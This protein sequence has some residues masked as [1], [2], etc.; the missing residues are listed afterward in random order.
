MPL[1]FAAWEKFSKED[2]ARVLKLVGVVAFRYSVVS[3]L[4]T[5][6]LEPI[7]HN[8]AKNVL[9]GQAPS[10]ASVFEILRPIYVSDDKF[11]GAFATLDMDTS[12]QGRRLARYVLF[13]L[14]SDASDLPRDHETDPGSIEHILPENPAQV[15]EGA[16]PA[17]G[18]AK[19]VYRV[20][21]LTPLEAVRNRE[22]GN[23]TFTEK[24]VAYGQSQYRM[25][26]LIPEKYPGEWT[27]A[28]IDARQLGLAER[29]A[30][31]WRSDYVQ[32]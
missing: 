9:S 1:L 24:R 30:H 4:N 22:I 19:Y 18:W 5:N 3:G 17:N 25:T 28:S 7:Y 27:T 31:V 16:I 13:K 12:G 2:F 21:N 6:E 8:A 11:K 14:E 10:V 32:G 26:S 29:A 23:G 20:G 15:W